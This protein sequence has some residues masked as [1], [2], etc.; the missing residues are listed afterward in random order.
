MLARLGAGWSPEQIS[1]RMARDAGHRM[2][3]YESI[4][5]FIYAQIRRTNDYAW[6]HYLPR[7][8]SRRG[9]RGRRGGSPAKTIPGRIPLAQRPDAPRSCPGHWEADLMLF[10]TYG[11]AILAAHDRSSRLTIITRPPGKA[12]GPIAE[13]LIQWLQP[14]PQPLRASISFDNGTEFARHQHIQAIGTPT[15][16]C[17][18]H[19]PWQK[20]GVENAIGRL[21]RYLPRKANLDCLNPDHIQ[22]AA[23][24]Y[25]NTLRKC[26][27]FKTPA[28]AFYDQL[29]HFKCE[30]TSQPALG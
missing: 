30:P 17:D 1:G 28:E 18:T 15:F 19:S 29:L 27:D 21:R 25:N 8:K 23:Q 22:R 14:L 7:A 9:W 10:A 16:F 3:S 6:R 4:Y 12:A 2:I 24:I 13:Q 5:R 20:G 26:L 11:Q